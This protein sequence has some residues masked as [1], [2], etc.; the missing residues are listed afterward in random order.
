L[1]CPGATPSQIAA[2]AASYKAE[3][4]HQAKAV[5]PEIIGV[6]F[7]Q[8]A[9]GAQG[10]GPATWTSQQHPH[11]DV[12]RARPDWTDW[13][14]AYSQLHQCPPWLT[15]KQSTDALEQGVLPA[16]TTTDPLYQARWAA[17]PEDLR[18]RLTAGKAPAGEV[19]P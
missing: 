3:G 4:Q 6:R 5:G 16:S 8:F 17:L 2:F 15:L 1:R 10:A 18:A 19:A 12:V 13:H 14:E 9:L 7:A 11:S